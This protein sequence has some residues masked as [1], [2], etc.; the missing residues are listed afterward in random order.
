MDEYRKHGI[1]PA[2][3]PVDSGIRATGENLP[4]EAVVRPQDREAHAQQLKAN[5]GTLLQEAMSMAQPGFDP[6]GGGGVDLVYLRNQRGNSIHL[7]R[8]GLLI[9]GVMDPSNDEGP[10][11]IIEREQ[12]QR[13]VEVRRLMRTRINRHDPDDKRMVLHELTEE[14][15]LEQHADWVDSSERRRMQEEAALEGF[16]EDPANRDD[17]RSRINWNIA[18][19]KSTTVN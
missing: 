14:E 3:N 17:F 15:Y 4:Q 19:T 5:A 13:T 2:N 1:D 9:P 10:F 16:D 18:S 7:S 6:L 11:L 8:A 12:L